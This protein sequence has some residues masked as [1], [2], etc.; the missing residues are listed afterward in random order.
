MK[1]SV[2]LIVKNEEEVL[3]RCLNCVQKFADEIVVVDTGSIDRTKLIAKKFTNNVYDFEW[4]DDFS[5]ARNFSF[6]KATCD[7]I[8]WLDADDVVKDSEIEKIKLLKQT[9]KPADVYM[10]HYA[11]AFDENGSSNFCFFRER[12][13][14]NRFGFEWKGFIHEAISPYG[15]IEYCD[16][17]IEHRKEKVLDRKRN[18]KIYR[19]NKDKGIK[20]DARA[21]YYYSK[22]LFYNQYY[23]KCIKEM[24]KFLLLSERKFE[25]NVVD[26]YL[27]ISKCFFFKNKFEKALK[28]LFKLIEKFKITS[29]IACEIGTVFLSLKNPQNAIFFFEGALNC[30]KNEKS[31]A[32]INEEYYYLIPY[33]QLC[34]IY[35]QT[36]NKEKAKFF[37]DK[38]K[39]IS[40]THPTVKYNEQFFL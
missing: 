5:A 4:I 20:F 14:R 38:A 39:Q 31:G 18:L 2:C 10:F 34:M 25:P 29:E 37:H 30:T 3:E 16:I 28:I 12:L 40:P 6:S 11:I 26:A 33:L 19:K 23:S 24:K 9:L 35:Y 22:E 13:L 7:Y 32:F 1:I 8:M 27:T 15:K 21:Q 36:G 17:T